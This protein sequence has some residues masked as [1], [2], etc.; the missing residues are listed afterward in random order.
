MRQS[1][2]PYMA[3]NEHYTTPSCVYPGRYSQLTES[4][5]L[6]SAIE[7]H[8]A[9]WSHPPAKSSANSSFN[10]MLFEANQMDLVS[11]SIC[12]INQNG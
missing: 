1:K 7:V 4:G 11:V 6:G 5:V 3:H 9:D 10:Q 2:L 12:Q 8:A